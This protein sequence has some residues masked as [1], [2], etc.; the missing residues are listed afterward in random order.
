MVRINDTFRIR[1]AQKT[2]VFFPILEI[3]TIATHSDV[4][5][6]THFSSQKNTR[7]TE[8]A[9][10]A[11]LLGSVVIKSAENVIYVD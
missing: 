8:T 10:S 5:A 9:E 7:T 2:P 11:Q 3:Q 6:F 1:R 4:T